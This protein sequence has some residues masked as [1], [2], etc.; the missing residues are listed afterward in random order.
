MPASAI[1]PIPNHNFFGTKE[2][3]MVK[4]KRLRL[5]FNPLELEIW[6]LRLSNARVNMCPPLSM[7]YWSLYIIF[8]L[9]FIPSFSYEQS[10]D[11]ITLSCLLLW[12]VLSGKF[13]TLTTGAN[14]RRWDKMKERLLT[15]VDSF[16]I[17]NVWSMILENF[18]NNH[19]RKNNIY[20][21]L[22]WEHCAFFRNCI[23]SQFN[24]FLYSFSFQLFSF[25]TH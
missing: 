17:F 9:L 4:H 18:K 15:V 20:I 14:E 5:L 16:K 19:I 21:L 22:D 1:L 7:K 13:Y 8:I 23:K 25:P 6:N 12:H 3:K 2:I 11:C 10:I 24:L